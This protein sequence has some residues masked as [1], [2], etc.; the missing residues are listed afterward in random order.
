MTTRYATALGCAVLL[1]AT[2]YGATA[3]A[4]T[5]RGDDNDN[6]LR[7]TAQADSI[8]AFAGNDRLYGLQ[9]PVTM[10]GGAVEDMV[11][12]GPGAEVLNAQ[13]GNDRINTGH[14]DKADFV[15]GGA[16]NDVIFMTGNDTAFG[17][18]GDDRFF[19]SYAG[20][21]MEIQC[22]A[23]EDTVIFNQ[24]SPGAKRK[25]CEHVVVKPAG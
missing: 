18:T 20:D 17:D 2:A 6:V 21:G 3:Q 7:G 11:M 9:G 25:D 12:G 10:A 24:P 16:G 5:V 14:D 4:A 19:A 22:G 13:V 1:A 15:H 8:R 23:G